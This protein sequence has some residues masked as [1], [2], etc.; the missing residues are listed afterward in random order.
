MPPNGSLNRGKYSLFRSCGKVCA[1][2]ELISVIRPVGLITWNI[3]QR[4]LAARQTSSRVYGFFS[5]SLVDLRRT[6]FELEALV[7]ST[8]RAAAALVKRT[9]G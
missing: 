2:P 8:A 6:T 5:G 3:D 4:H 7:N 9:P 1:K